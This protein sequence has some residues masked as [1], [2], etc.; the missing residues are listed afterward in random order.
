MEYPTDMTRYI[1][2]LRAINVGG[3]VIKMD[4]LRAHF[5]KMGLGFSHVETFIASGNVMFDATTRHTTGNSTRLEEQ[6]GA[7]LREALGYEVA[8]FLR[9]RAELEG[10]SQYLPFRALQDEDSN[11]TLYVGFVK[12]PL[13]AAAQ[14]I[15]QSFT[16]P[17]DDFHVQSQG[18][19]I[20]WRCH[21]RSSDSTFN[22]ARL[23][24][25]LGKAATF[26]NITTIRKLAAREAALLK[27]D[28]H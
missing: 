15:V 9:T 7:A 8:T 20:Y 18:R 14:Q 23:E 2:F 10:V 26:R 25:A 27:G 11:M 22:L 16:T 3:H 4:R 24:K 5:E 1:A 13:D 17:V 28:E 6:I 19:E 21:I 12:S